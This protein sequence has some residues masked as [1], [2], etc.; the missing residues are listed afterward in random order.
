MG[1]ISNDVRRLVEDCHYFITEVLR[2]EKLSDYAVQ[3]RK[4]LLSNFSVVH[5][6][7]PQ[8]FDINTDSLQ[9]DVSDDNGR[10]S[11]G[12]SVPS[13]EA[14][15]ASDCQ[16]DGAQ[17]CF[18]DIP[19]VAVQDLSPIIKQDYLEKRRRDHSFFGSEW[20]KRWCVIYKNIFYY[21]GTE[22]DKQQKGAFYINGYKAEVVTHLRKDSKKN[23]CFELSA[24]G[25]RSFQFVA[26]SPQDARDWVDEINFITKDLQSEQIPCDEDEVEDD[27]A[28][29]YDDIEA[30][31][32]GPVPPPPGAL[33]HAT[34]RG[35]LD[36][37]G[38]EI[39]EVVPDECLERADNNSPDRS[40][41]YAN[42]FQGL[43]DCEAD[44]PDE[45]SFQR[46]DLIY[47]LSKEYNIHGWWIGEL[48]GS[49]GIVPKEFL[50]PAYIL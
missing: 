44:E 45:L 26:N 31:M 42:Y 15:I 41:D 39:Y 8:E 25:K 37:E 1:T 29:S 3:T 23:A 5:K 19:I 24:P 40:K 22:K 28:C 43:W 18:E 9:E 10:F 6:R 11:L 20:Q 36:D 12:R 2:D 47:I 33:P 50:H 30:V 49:V 16:D 32:G 17:E 4:V 35:E 21:F 14:S 34:Q 27:D 38:D 7:N 48:N 46:G 13:D